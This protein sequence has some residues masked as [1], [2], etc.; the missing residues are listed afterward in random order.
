MGTNA[1]SYGNEVRL[2]RCSVQKVLSTVPGTEVKYSLSNGSSQQM[3]NLVRLIVNGNVCLS[4]CLVLCRQQRPLR[5]TLAIQSQQKHPKVGKTHLSHHT[6]LKKKQK[7]RR[8]SWLQI[9]QQ[10]K[11]LCLNSVLGVSLRR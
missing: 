4:V 9:K 3:Q 5:F 11:C 1:V 2:K 8:A 6:L 7:L 10:I